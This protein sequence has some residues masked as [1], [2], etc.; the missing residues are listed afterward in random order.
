MQTIR[1]VIEEKNRE[2]KNYELYF[3]NNWWSETYSTNIY[4]DKFTREMK[5][6]YLYNSSKR[7]SSKQMTSLPKS[8]NWNITDGDYR[9]KE[10]KGNGKDYLY[11]RELNA[12]INKYSIYLAILLTSILTYSVSSIIF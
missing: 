10:M 9:N 12:K 7:N 5:L 11:Y 4:N 6:L 1:L 8:K 2:D 3:P